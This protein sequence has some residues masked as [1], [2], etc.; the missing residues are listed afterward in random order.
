METVY[1]LYDR[2]IT[3]RLGT[4]VPLGT[5]GTI[6]G[7]MLGQT[8]LDTYY[9]VLFDHLPKNSLDAILLGGHNQQCRIKVRSYHLVNYSHSLRVRSMSNLQQQRSLPSENVWEK[10]LLE[11]SSTTR[12]TQNQQQ[13]QQQQTPTRILKRNTNEPNS[14]TTTPKSAPA[15]TTTQGKPDVL[16]ILAAAVKEQQQN[17]NSSVPKST[18]K[19]TLSQTASATPT[20]IPP[21]QKSSVLPPTPVAKPPEPEITLSTMNP[22]S[23]NKPEPAVP[24]TAF[25]TNLGT[26]S[27]LLRAIQ[28][29]KQSHNLPQQQ[30]NTHSPM[31]QQSWDSISPPSLPIIQQKP[32]DMSPSIQKPWESHLTPSLISAQQQQMFEQFISHPATWET[33]P[34]PPQQQQQRQQQQQSSKSCT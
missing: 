16:E 31:V 29:S 6:I 10:K 30:S 21:S 4:G 25:P 33:S 27:F 3:V 14:I 12:P 28:D 20:T 8:H 32:N 19:S 1:D 9:E 11:Q 22:I 5:R 18:E 15:S 13:Q 23:P 2:V 17:T 24:L 26:E 34:P 7:V